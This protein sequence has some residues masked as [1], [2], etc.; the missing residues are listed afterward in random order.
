MPIHLNFTIE[1]D[2]DRVIKVPK[3][4][5]HLIGYDLIKIEVKGEVDY[6]CRIASAYQKSGVVESEDL[7]I[8]EKKIYRIRI[9]RE[10]GII[11]PG[12]YEIKV[13][14]D[15]ERSKWDLKG[16]IRKRWESEWIKIKINEPEGEDKFLIEE[17]KEVYPL[18]RNKDYPEYTF[19]SYKCKL[20]D[21]F[22]VADFILTHFPTSTYAGWAFFNSNLKGIITI[23]RNKDKEYIERIKE[24]VYKIIK[25]VKYREI[26][27]E[28]AKGMFNE[29]IFDQRIENMEKAKEFC[30][31]FAKAN[32]N[33]SFSGYLLATG[34]LN[35]LFLGDIKGACEMLKE[36]LRLKWDKPYITEEHK[37][38]IREVIR[39]MEEEGVCKRE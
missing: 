19:K 14:F 21:I 20:L 18:I 30:L 33:F 22:Q 9:E 11:N 34:G 17:L 7:G 13:I 36:S 37:E 2:T 15:T 4:R 31:N 16:C 10:L 12:L 6:D 1:N 28:Y 32:P 25:G 24:G 26:V 29:N 3:N 27:K 8:K 38:T 39:I 5:G 35:A 23:A